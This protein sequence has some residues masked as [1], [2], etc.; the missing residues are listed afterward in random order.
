VAP[1]EVA[2][3]SSGVRGRA[4]IGPLKTIRAGNQPRPR[5][6]PLTRSSEK[7][8]KAAPR[9]LPRIRGISINFPGASSTEPLFG[10]RMPQHL[11]GVK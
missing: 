9:G 2:W 8:R 7:R 11:G 10:T 3:A 6:E 5:R 1:G 4:G